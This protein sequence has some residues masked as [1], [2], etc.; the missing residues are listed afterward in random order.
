MMNNEIEKINFF[1][2]NRPSVCRDWTV[3]KVDVII[4]KLY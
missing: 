2:E 4:L 3:D 1:F